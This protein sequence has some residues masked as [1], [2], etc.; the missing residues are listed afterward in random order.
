MR[1]AE[2]GDAVAQR[3]DPLEGLGHLQ[4]AHH[5]DELLVAPAADQVGGAQVVAQH[6]GDA[7]QRAVGGLVAAALVDEPEAVQIGHRHGQQALGRQLAVLAGGRA[8]V[9][10]GL[11]QHRPVAAVVEPGQ[12]VALQQL[13][14]LGARLVGQP[15]AHLGQRHQHEQRHQQIGLHQRLQHHWRQFVQRR[16]ELAAQAQRHAAGDQADRGAPADLLGQPGVQDDGRQQPDQRPPQPAVPAQRPHAEERMRRHAAQQHPER[17]LRAA[18]A[19]Q[20]RGHRQQADAA[21]AGR[22]QRACAEAQEQRDVEQMQRRAGPAELAQQLPE[23]GVDHRFLRGQD[24]AGRG[25]DRGRAHRVGLG[26]RTESPGAIDQEWKKLKSG[27][28][29]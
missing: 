7:R 13:A 3:L 24:T 4:P 5:H 28:S 14:E 2:L 27:G 8:L 29:A 22:G 10:P 20:H 18:D 25:Q 19:L 12:A 16:G 15:A 9:E 6:P 23:G 11:G 1:H 17:A 21:D 26:V